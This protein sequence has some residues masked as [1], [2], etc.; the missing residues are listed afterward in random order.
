MPP[1]YTIVLQFDPATQVFMAR[2]P[3]LAGCMTQGTT[4]EEAFQQAHA[5]IEVWLQQLDPAAIPPPNY[6]PQPMLM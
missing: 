1:S 5:A 4:Y 6:Y 2:V 3:E